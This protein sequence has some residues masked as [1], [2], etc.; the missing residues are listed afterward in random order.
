M[1]NSRARAVRASVSA[2]TAAVSARSFPAGERRRDP[3]GRE[4]R[5]ELRRRSSRPP[6]PRAAPWARA[7]RRGG[8]RLRRSRSR[9]KRGGRALVARA[10]P[11]APPARDRGP[12]RALRLLGRLAHDALEARAEGVA[13]RGSAA[14]RSLATSVRRAAPSSVAF[15][16][17]QASRSGAH[18]G[19]EQANRRDPASGAAARIDRDVDV[20]DRRGRSAPR[21]GGLP[22]AAVDEHDGVARREP[23]RPGVRGLLARRRGRPR[24]PRAARRLRGARQAQADPLAPPLR[25]PASF[26]RP[27]RIFASTDGSRSRV[28]PDSSTR[29]RRRRARRAAAAP[30]AGSPPASMLATTRSNSPAQAASGPA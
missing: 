9:N 22:A 10:P 19:D 24:R 6:G 3:A 21:A 15:S 4:R 12:A 2:A 27:V 30:R 20:H 29:P 13:R 17:I 7:G 5:G 28:T 26:Q 16:A 8:K 23:P 25:R 18:R 14:S 1:R 11:R